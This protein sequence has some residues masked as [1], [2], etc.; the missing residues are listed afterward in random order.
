MVQREVISDTT[1]TIALEQRTPLSIK[2]ISNEDAISR[3][4][5]EF[6]LWNAGKDLGYFHL[7]NHAALSAGLKCRP[8][9][10]TIKDTLFWLQDV[11]KKKR[12]N[13]K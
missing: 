7:N 1:T 8:F 10:E 2:W 5:A 12:N 4:E 11:Q 9:C 13:E 3:E 6:P